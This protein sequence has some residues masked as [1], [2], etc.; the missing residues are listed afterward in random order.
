MCRFHEIIGG[1]PIISPREQDLQTAELAPYLEKYLRGVDVS[2]RRRLQ[3]IR[4]ARELGVGLSAGRIQI[5]NYHAD[6]P[7]DSFKKQIV[8]Y[9]EE[10]GEREECIDSVESLLRGAESTV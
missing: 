8:I 9:F 2:A 5:F 6:A 3:I 1:T 10:L 7:Q 4:L